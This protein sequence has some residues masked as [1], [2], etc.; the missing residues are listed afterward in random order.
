VVA[1]T[2]EVRDVA[3]AEGLVVAEFNPAKGLERLDVEGQR[4]LDV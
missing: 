1:K 3:G 2:V 4:S